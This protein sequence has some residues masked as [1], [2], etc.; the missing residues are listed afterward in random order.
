[1][2]MV[3]LVFLPFLYVH[4]CSPHRTEDLTSISRSWRAPLTRLFCFE[5]IVSSIIFSTICVN[6]VGLQIIMVLLEVL[7]LMICLFNPGDYKTPEDP[8]PVARR[9]HKLSA[10]TV[11]IGLFIISI[12]VGVYE[13]FP[14]AKAV[15][16]YLKV[17]YVLLIVFDGLGV[18]YIILIAFSESG[19]KTDK[20]GIK[21][22][23][24]LG[25]RWTGQTDFVEYFIVLL[26][27]FIIGIYIRT[28]CVATS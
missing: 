8:R 5:F 28:G 20:N 25:L 3:L 27:L 11:F 4:T 6:S 18:G 12:L 7:L 22:N 24:N 19:K 13:V 14:A 17:I 1:M 10:A 15:P 16:N 26:P 2:A 21:N 9:I 23:E